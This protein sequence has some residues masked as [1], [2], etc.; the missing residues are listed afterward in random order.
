MAYYLMCSKLIV[1]GLPQYRFREMAFTFSG[2]IMQPNIYIRAVKIQ[3]SDN[4]KVKRKAS[5]S[6]LLNAKVWGT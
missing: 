3:F 1:A 4:K 2:T 6:C 5:L